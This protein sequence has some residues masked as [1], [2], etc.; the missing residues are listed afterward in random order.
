M[1]SYLETGD[2]NVIGMDWSALCEFE[3]LSATRGVR[4]AGRYLGEFLNWLEQM[5]VPLETIHI[6]G[7]SMGAHVAGVAGGRVGKGR[8]ARITGLDPARPGFENARIEHKLDHEDA[9]LV[10]VVHTYV[11]LLSLQSPIGHIDFYPNG[12]RFQ[13]GCPDFTEI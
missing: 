1:P 10:D 11:R 13:P 6:I 8:I 7:H 9:S 2:Y 3:Y 4:I 12:G 5:G